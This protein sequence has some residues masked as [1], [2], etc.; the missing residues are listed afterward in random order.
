M[1][2]T[3]L[4]GPYRKTMADVMS[5]I[6]ERIERYN[7][8]YESAHGEKLYEHLTWRI[9][10]DESMLEKLRRNGVEATT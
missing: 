4:Y 9:K 1:S 8:E 3:D 7:R 6:K 5:R 2:Q 10:H